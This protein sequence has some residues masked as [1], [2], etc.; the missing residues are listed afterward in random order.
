MSIEIEVQ[1]CGRTIIYLTR[2]QVKYH[3]DSFVEAVEA[4]RNLTEVQQ[5][6]ECNK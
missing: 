4:L 1:E 5:C 2:H 6:E 3:F